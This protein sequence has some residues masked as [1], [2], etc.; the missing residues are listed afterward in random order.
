MST[1]SAPVMLWVFLTILWHISCAHPQQAYR[2]AEPILL[3]G[4]HDTVLSRLWI[5]YTGEDCI[6][7]RNC[8]NITIDDCRLEQ[9]AGCGVVLYQCR[10]IRIRNCRMD[11]VASGVYAVHSTGIQVERLAVSNVM[12]PSPRGQMVQFDSVWGS[13]NFITNSI[14]ENGVGNSGAE[15]AINLYKTTGTAASPVLVRNN[16][17][18]GGGPSHSG[19]GIML[20]DGG[21]GF[22]LADSNILVNPGQYGIAIAG[23]SHITVQH[24]IIFARQQPF[25]NVGLYIWNQSESNCGNHTI[26]QNKV[27]WTNS[28]GELNIIWD[29]RN[30]S[31]VNGIGN[32]PYDSTISEEALPTILIP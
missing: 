22:I 25:T 29:G 31:P 5:A 23:G 32:N 20:G 17:I 15:D 10:N 28:L 3:E 7:L 8:Y 26:R 4:V 16:R 24:N 14:C 18:R 13:G 19:G 27:N 12:G 6:V 21:G 30:C 9:A 1:Y 11:S 2:R